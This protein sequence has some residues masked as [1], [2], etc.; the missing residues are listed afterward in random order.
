MLPKPS[1]CLTKVATDSSKP[2]GDDDMARRITA[3]AR[4]ELVRALSERYRAGTR[5]EKA[6]ILDEFGAV[7][8]YH[9][10]HAIR[11]LNAAAESDDRP[12]PSSRPRVYDEAV[13][14]ALVVLW[15]ASDRVCGKRLRA[16]LP[17]R[18]RSSAT[19]RRAETLRAWVCS[20]QLGGGS[21]A[22]PKNP[23]SAR[24]E[25]KRSQGWARRDP[26]D[27]LAFTPIS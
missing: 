4:R 18:P 13:R 16:L 15:E 3:S 10:K 14:Q 24:N 17:A 19:S 8:G 7:S 2:K 12:R 1:R 22:R 20:T 26:R 5:E 23:S 27:S 25:S 6:R 9:R 21:T 11:V